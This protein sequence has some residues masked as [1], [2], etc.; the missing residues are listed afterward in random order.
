[1]SSEFK[2]FKNDHQAINVGPSD[3]LSI[4][5]DYHTI[6]IY[7]DISVSKGDEDAKQALQDVIDILTKIKDAI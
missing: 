3:S 7:G 6:A 1:M 4:E 2:P 5:N